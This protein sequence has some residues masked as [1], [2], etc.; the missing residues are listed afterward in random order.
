MHQIPE[1]W[2]CTRGRMNTTGGGNTR[3]LA[4]KVRNK[5]DNPKWLRQKLSHDDVYANRGIQF[6]FYVCNF[7]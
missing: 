3:L 1:S 4:K 7:S 2:D 6:F 5:K